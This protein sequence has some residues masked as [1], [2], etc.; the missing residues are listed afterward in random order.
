MI[1]IVQWYT[2]IISHW[3]VLTY[4][5]LAAS[6]VKKKWRR[7]TKGVKARSNKDQPPTQ[8]EMKLT[9]HNE[10]LPIC[11][12]TTVYIRKVGSQLLFSFWFLLGWSGQILSVIVNFE[13]PKELINQWKTVNKAE[14]MWQ[15]FSVLILIQWH[16][17]EML[18]GRIWSKTFLR[19]NKS[20]SIEPIQL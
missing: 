3:I 9:L 8:T 5:L 20:Q 7:H 12:D 11:T 19:A 6:I 18:T 17:P 15:E 1:W 13:P 10:N 4:T 2:L 14:N 16:K